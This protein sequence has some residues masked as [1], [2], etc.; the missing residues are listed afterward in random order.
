M[1]LMRIICVDVDV[2]VAR[3]YE[4]C[5]Y[6]ITVPFSHRSQAQAHTLQLLRKTVKHSR[7]I[8]D[9]QAVGRH[10]AARFSKMSRFGNVSVLTQP[11]ELNE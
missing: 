3:L 4:Y 1:E 10:V 11:G 9:V 6:S 2:C 8:Q 7:S 5:D